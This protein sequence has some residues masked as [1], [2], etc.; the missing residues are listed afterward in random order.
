MV[1]GVGNMVYKSIHLI[2]SDNYGKV[3]VEG[4]RSIMYDAYVLEIFNNENIYL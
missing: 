1:W 3:R 2:Y 4:V